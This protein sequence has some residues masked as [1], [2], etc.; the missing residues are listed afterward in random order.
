MA[1]G[2][3]LVQR[4]TLCGPVGSSGGLVV[5]GGRE[6][7]MG[8]SVVGLSRWKSV[9]CS[10]SSSRGGGGERRWR[11]VKEEVQVMQNE[12]TQNG[13]SILPPAYPAFGG[14]S[15]PSNEY[16]GF[17]MLEEK[18][19]F[20]RERFVVRFSEVGDRGTT[21]L[22]ML[23]SLLQVLFYRQ[24]VEQLYNMVVHTSHIV[25]GWTF[26]LMSKNWKYFGDL[27]VT[28]MARV[29]LYQAVLLAIACIL[30]F[31]SPHSLSCR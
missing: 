16:I 8:K 26:N 25:C 12:E 9:Q 15:S 11:A 19:A 1:A 28:W 7:A 13:A 4:A 21:S 20:Y 23:A 14:R 29:A 27:H 10:S 17:G 31:P 30:F 22:E 24:I 18:D 2:S 5:A 6:M 3:A